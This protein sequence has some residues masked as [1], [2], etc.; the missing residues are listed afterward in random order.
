M[1]EYRLQF[2]ADTVAANRAIK[3]LLGEIQKVSK[4]FKGVENASR[5]AFHPLSLAAY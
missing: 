4:D 3:S 2:S 5:Q 1:A